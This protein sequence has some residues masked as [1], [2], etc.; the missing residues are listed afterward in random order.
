MEM[1]YL[2]KPRVHFII[3]IDTNELQI[4]AVVRLTGYEK[5][6]VKTCFFRSFRR[7]KGLLST[8]LLDAI[9]FI[10]E[11][12]HHMALGVIEMINNVAGYRDKEGFFSRKLVWKRI[13]DK[14]K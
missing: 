12:P 13:G 3:A 9:G 5:G 4:H 2:L 7:P 11:C 10:H 1:M 14:D 8:Q 6:M